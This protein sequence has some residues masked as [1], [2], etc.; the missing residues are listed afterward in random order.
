MWL[1]FVRPR[2]KSHYT[3]LVSALIRKRS[4]CVASACFHISIYAIS[5]SA[6]S[7]A[8]RWFV[9]YAPHNLRDLTP[10]SA[11]FRGIWYLLDLHNVLFLALYWQ[12][13]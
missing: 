1:K 11:F 8:Q 10:T 12:I 3:L 5:S 7:P 2:S 13:E 9:E 4:L 6:T